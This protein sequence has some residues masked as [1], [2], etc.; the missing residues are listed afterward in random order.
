M[1]TKPSLDNKK[2]RLPEMNSWQRKRNT[3]LNLK[4]KNESLK[5][6]IKELNSKNR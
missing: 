1:K 5:L 2:L 3:N 4:S 6:K